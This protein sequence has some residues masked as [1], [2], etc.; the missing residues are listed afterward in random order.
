MVRLLYIFTRKQKKKEK[1]KK[2]L[3]FKFFFQKIF[4]YYFLDVIK[5][6]LFQNINKHHFHSQILSEKTIKTIPNTSNYKTE[7]GLLKRLKEKTFVH[8]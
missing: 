5:N 2:K 3:I 7:I 8:Y 6:I 1:R 4:F